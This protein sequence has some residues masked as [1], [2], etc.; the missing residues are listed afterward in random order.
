MTDQPADPAVRSDPSNISVAPD[1]A[2]DP[3]ILAL[4]VGS[5]SVRAIVYDALGRAL[6]GAG[7]HIPYQMDTTPDGGVEI[8]ADRL[9]G[10]VCE[11][12]DGVLLHSKGALDRLG[13]VACCT[14]WHSL[15]GVG[16]DGHP[17]TPV[18]SWNDTRSREDAAALLERVDVDSVHSRTGTRP[19]ASYWPAKLRWLNR[20]RPDAFGRVARWMSPGEYIHF[21]LFGRTL[22]SVSMASGTGLFN[23]NVCAWDDGMLA[24]SGIDSGQISPLARDDQS[25]S[26]LTAEFAKR[27]PALAQVPWTP[28]LGD[29]ACSNVGSGCVTRDAASL[30]VGTSGAMRVC[31]AAD[32]VR[33]PRG[34]W[35]YRANRQYALLGGALSN[36]GDV[37]AWCLNTLRLDS[38]DL[39]AELASIA[40]DAH[41]L[42]V[43][44]FFSGERSTGWMDHARAAI[45]GMTLSTRPVEILRAALEAVTYRFGAIY[46]RLREEV[47]TITAIVASGGGILNSPVWAQ[48]MAD[49]IGVPVVASAVPEAS[50]RGAALLALDSLGFLDSLSSVPVPSGKLCEPEGSRRAAYRQGRERQER[51]YDL[52][53]AR[54]P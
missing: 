48:M 42:T 24:E 21:R 43:L 5:S 16:A 18:F 39:E 49:V 25:L 1:H 29:G 28:A 38:N 6:T 34:L 44:P 46:E 37:Y 26:G 23:P 17:L 3:L 54:K 4:D 10:I 19:H 11:C 30:M 51:L 33:I 52:L 35:C 8:G 50:S 20:T 45:N 2:R 7:N 22:C 47:P 27:W 13:V 40:P 31:W 14:F 41:G 36:A 9:L 32:R 53:V 12:I 15:V